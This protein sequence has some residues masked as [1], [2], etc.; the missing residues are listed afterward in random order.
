M[1]S[2]KS[3]YKLEGF[4]KIVLISHLQNL[5]NIYFYNKHY[6]IV[7]LGFINKLDF[8]NSISLDKK[9]LN[10]KN[11]RFINS[12]I[13]YNIFRLVFKGKGFRVRLFR[14]LNKL[15]LNFGHSHWTKFKLFNTWRMFKLRRQN[16]VLISYDIKNC[17]YFKNDISSVRIMNRYTQRGLRLK[18]TF[19]KKRF[20]KISQYVSSLH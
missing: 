9:Q 7:F 14:G 16:Y 6:Y 5:I 4:K 2:L 1:L 17:S 15:T 18:K 13:L 12:Y 3:N 11:N 8:L 19:I 20:G 10:I